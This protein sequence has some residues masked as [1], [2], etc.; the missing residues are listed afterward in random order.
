V[1]GLGLGLGM[2]ETSWWA[3]DGTSQRASDV[4]RHGRGDEAIDS[5]A[6]W[7]VK[8]EKKVQALG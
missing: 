6:H 3:K 5:N 8:L 1:A 4:C 7:A 2:R